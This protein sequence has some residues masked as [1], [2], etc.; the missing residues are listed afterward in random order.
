MWPKASF[1]LVTSAKL[2]HTLVSHYR[3][4]WSKLCKQLA[5]FQQRHYTANIIK[6]LRQDEQVAV[7]LSEEGFV[8]GLRFLSP[9]DC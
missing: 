7:Q 5:A 4:A 2:W 1:T 6:N 3:G 8:S 9:T